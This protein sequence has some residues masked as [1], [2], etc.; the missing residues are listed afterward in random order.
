[1]CVKC[2]R[3]NYGERTET[4]TLRYFTAKNSEGLVK[5]DSSIL[6]FGRF[7]QP[8]LLAENQNC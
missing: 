7:S 2:M 6:Y 5:V 3:Q 1:M 8:A 4:D